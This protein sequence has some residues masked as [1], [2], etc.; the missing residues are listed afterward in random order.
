MRPFNSN[1]K[2]TA[3]NPVN[4][5][6]RVITFDQMPSAV[7]FLI[8]EVSELKL[9]LQTREAKPQSQPEAKY[10]YSIKGLAAFLNCSQ[11][12]A[13]KLKNTG[14]IKYRQIGRKVVFETSEV[15]RAMEGH[16]SG[17]RSRNYQK[18]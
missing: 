1:L 3:K 17:N 16:I 15:L 9:M 14:K 6:N 8:G 5:E 11:V 7:A 12:T 2:E 10:I 18:S 13:Q 4:P